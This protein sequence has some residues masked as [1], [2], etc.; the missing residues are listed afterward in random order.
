MA[1]TRMNAIRE[2][3][4][5]DGVAV[6]E[7]GVILG[8]LQSAVEERGLFYP[9][10][11]ASLSY[12]TLGGTVAENAG[13]PRAV[14][15]GVTRDYI[16]GMTVVM[17]TG[18]VL[19]LGRRTHKGVA[20]YE[21][22]SLMCGSE[23]TLAIITELTVRLIPRP[24]AV[25]TAVMV[26]PSSAAAANA[27]QAVMLLGTVP[28][29][30]EYLDRTTIEAVRPLAP[31]RFPTD[32]GAA[33]IVEMDADTADGALAQ[34]ERAARAGEQAGAMEVLVAQTEA[35]RAALWES[36]H[37]LS[38]A[39]KRVKGQKVSE[40][41]V[42]PRSRLPEMVRRMDEIGAKH[43]LMT[44]AFGHAG[45]GNLHIQILF[46]DAEAHRQAIDACMRDVTV[47]AIALG[48]S[49]SGEHGVGVAKKMLLP[50]E[51]S[52]ELIAL[53]KRL[54]QAFDPAGILNPGKIF[55]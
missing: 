9:P 24:R 22:A 41:G 51:Q 21:L 39:T 7:P 34:L 48:G 30:L 2:I 45:D 43:G 54:K 17:P 6:A 12:C 8:H 15:Y 32:A 25:H 49:L 26:F 10:D 37:L 35:Q 28:R 29:T 20:G 14:K 44:C 11:P 23:G 36:R 3:H 31:Y 52:A 1:M 38:Q 13:G 46:D 27:V 50:L 19:R 42:V 18:E 33:L 47:A 53:Q 55:P 40:D 5:G 4:E 16:L